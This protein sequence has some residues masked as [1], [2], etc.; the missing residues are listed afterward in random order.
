MSRILLHPPVT[1]VSF[2]ASFKFSRAGEV[3]VPINHGLPCGCALSRGSRRSGRRGFT[4]QTDMSVVHT[5]CG[6]TLGKLMFVSSGPVRHDDTSGY[7]E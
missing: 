2:L 6:Q 5:R 4:I 7:M 3:A 1:L